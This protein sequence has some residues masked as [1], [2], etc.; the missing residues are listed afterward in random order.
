MS[1]WHF[2]GRD[3][4]DKVMS[5]A[6]NFNNIWAKPTCQV[7][8]NSNFLQTLRRRS[9]CVEEVSDGVKDCRRKAY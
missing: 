9:C 6:H 8:Q 3:F 1:E 7:G 2:R 4:F 5:E